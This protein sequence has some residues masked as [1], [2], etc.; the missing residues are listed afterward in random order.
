MSYQ[1]VPFG[2]AL[3][4]E[5]VLPDGNT[6]KYPQAHVYDS[7]GSEVVGSPFNLAHSANAL[8]RNVAY[9][10]AIAGRYTAI[11]VTYNEV[12][13]TTESNKHGRAK[14]QFEID[15]RIAEVTAIKAQTDQFSFTGGNVDADTQVNSDKTGYALTVPEKD[16]IAD[17]VWNE[18]RSQHTAVGSFGEA[19]QG[20]ISTGRADNLD[21]L[22]ATISSR[23]SESDAGTRFGTTDGKNTAI[24][25]KTDQ[26]QYTGGNVHA[27]SKVVSDKTGYSTTSGDK[28]GTADAVWDELKAGHVAAGSFGET[29][30]GIVSVSRA[31]NLDN[32]DVTVSSREAETDA[33]TR[34]G[35]SDAKLDTIQ[36]QTDKMN[37]TGSNIDAQVI[38]NEDKTG[39]TI[40]TV[41]KDAIVDLVWNETRVGHTAIGSFGE[42]NQGVVSDS[43]AGNLD[44]LDVTVSSRQSESDASV[45]HTATQADLT[46]IENKVDVIDANVDGV[47]T[48]TDQLTFTGSNVN[49]NTKINSD[50]INYTLTGADQD[51]IV[52]KIWSEFLSGHQTVGTTGKALSDAQLNVSPVAIASAVWDALTINHY[53][54][55]SFGKMVADTEEKVKD[56]FNELASPLYGLGA[57][58]NLAINNTSAII[59]E[60]DQNEVKI[61]AILP[62][63]S[64]STSTIVGQVNENEVKIDILTANL[65]VTEGNIIAAVEINEAKIDS[66]AGDVGTI[67]N[68]TT[69]RFVV[70]AKL[71][72]PLSGTKN[73]EF[74]LRLFNT[75]GQ[76]EA[77]DSAPTIRI[78]RLDF[79]TDIVNGAVMTGMGTDG[80][81]LY[82]YPVTASTPE[83]HL[84][85]EATVV[86]NGETRLVPSVT[87]VTEFSSDLDNIQSQLTVVNAKVTST[88]DGVYNATYGLSALKTG[89]A[90]IIAEVNAN[91]VKIDQVKVRTNLIPND[92]ATETSITA[93][94][95]T[96]LTRPTIVDIDAS[97]AATEAAIRGVGN[98]DLTNVYNVFDVSDLLASNDPRLDTLD[99]NIS[100]RST[101]VAS[102]VWNYTTRTITNFVLPS[103]EVDKVWKYLTGGMTTANSIGKL[104]VDNIDASISSRAESS[105]VI[106]ALVGVAQQSTLQNVELLVI[107]KNDLNA[108]K[109]DDVQTT[110]DSIQVYTD[111][112]PVDPARET[113]LT[114]HHN[115]VL[116]ELSNVESKVDGVQAK[117]DNLPIDPASQSSVVQIPTNPV[118]NTD[119]RLNYLDASIAS[120]STLQVADLATLA[121]KDDVQDVTDTLLPELGTIETKVDAIGVIT[122]SIEE[123]TDNLPDDPTSE[124]LATANKGE[125]LTEIGNIPTPG[126]TTPAAV[127]AYATRELTVSPDIY[128][129]DVSDLATSADVTNAKVD[130]YAN[131]M[132]TVYNTITGNNE[133]I[134]W[135]DK[136]G[137]RVS[138]TNC[139]VTVK[140]E[141]GATLWTGT[142]PTPNSD[143]VFVFSEATTSFQAFKNY[144]VV[145]TIT[146]DGQARTSQKPFFTVG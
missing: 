146:V 52:D 12:G 127:W 132:S 91:E 42:S 107:S 140:D 84:L 19:S 141:G 83:T 93:V 100:S 18:T 115:T 114:Q 143:G 73:Y 34:D 102:D 59:A 44:N 17:R 122:S 144:Y 105:E 139:T 116:N 13:H 48:K 119:L 125:I 101:L 61:D 87:E 66:V 86:E 29:N 22:D 108:S 15:A 72:K 82:V 142:E 21:N 41:D 62:A 35:I 103:S 14:D 88:N 130:Q 80:A 134:A 2:S 104:L 51:L 11:Y 111:R 45:R 79:G 16:D 23:E 135:A 85:V 37:F 60:V 5:L 113:T 30:Q 95:A 7:A 24:K 65:V 131:S 121:E 39:Y 145:I 112:I 1:H 9:T 56:N 90:G 50:K 46:N 67:Q 68:N 3:I 124:L 40:T 43:R 63:I 32:L 54:D 55:D 47:K 71:L 98:Y 136:N 92:P 4:L 129:A 28:A 97:L 26:L 69:S 38:V 118:R 25:V 138:G 31:D 8:Y 120:R 133:V 74:H 58:R 78:R 128:K 75:Q 110:V 20:I 94:N 27:D 36:A 10:P 109:I 53:D 126:G 33:D 70:P 137:A 81:Y 6:G 77:P 76:A 96:V 64:T 117:T 49:A 106:D 99:A 57:Q 89:Q 123:R